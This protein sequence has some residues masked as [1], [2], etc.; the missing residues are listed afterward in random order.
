MSI[1]ATPAKPNPREYKSPDRTSIRVP[2]DDGR[3]A[4]VGPNWRPLPLDFHNAAVRNGCV[5]RRA[6]ATDEGTAGFE[7][8]A[9]K[10]P[11]AGPAIAAGTDAAVQVGL[12]AML[13][14]DEP[15]DFNDANGLPD[16]KVLS[17]LVGF[18]VDASQASRVLRALQAEAAQGD[19]GEEE[20]DD[21]DG[22]GA[23]TAAPVAATALA[24]VRANAADEVDEKTA[25]RNKK[26]A[27]IAAKAKQAKKTGD[28]VRRS[29]QSA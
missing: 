17:R 15:G 7:P 18:E 28:K 22:E 3:M 20:E 10:K 8:D 25:L 16:L 5:V 26:K 19:E 1:K 21:A 9:N 4:V 27:E 14:R 11:A 29:A 2:L 12:L 13:G 6:G 24:A 23:T